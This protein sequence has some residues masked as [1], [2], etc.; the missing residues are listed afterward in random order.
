[1]LEI[2]KYIKRFID[3]PLPL[4]CFFHRVAQWVGKKKFCAIRR[5]QLEVHN[6]LSA[7][8]KSANLVC[9]QF[10]L[11]QDEASGDTFVNALPLYALEV[12]SYG[13]LLPS[14]TPI[15]PFPS[16]APILSSFHLPLFLSLLLLPL[17][18][19][20]PPPAS[21]SLHSSRHGADRHSSSAGTLAQVDQVSHLPGDYA[22]CAFLW[23][24]AAQLEVFG[25]TMVCCHVR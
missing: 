10:G 20:P 5:E 12:D 3:V 17:L 6:S 21:L 16:P 7:E 14:C 19:T 23:L 24:S 25:A 4:F 13:C 22:A 18:I 2:N 8:M 9:G 1:M 15:P 11:W